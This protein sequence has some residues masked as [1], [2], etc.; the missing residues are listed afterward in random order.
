MWLQLIRD[1]EC[2]K[3]ALFHFFQRR[4]TQ[5]L[6]VRYLTPGH[7]YEFCLRTCSVLL[8]YSYFSTFLISFQIYLFVCLSVCL[9]VVM[10]M[11][12]STFFE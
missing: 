10:L 5:S 8:L 11:S 4:R 3:L 12:V 9:M 7:S 1:Q 6:R 2:I